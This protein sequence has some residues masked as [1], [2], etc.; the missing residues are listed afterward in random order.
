MY[1]IQN[2]T[3]KE[4][5]LPEGR[6]MKG[7]FLKVKKLHTPSLTA[8]IQ[9]GF[10]KVVHD[11]TSTE[12]ALSLYITVDDALFFEKNTRLLDFDPVDV[13]SMS[14]LDMNKISPSFWGVIE[15]LADCWG[16][17]LMSPDD[18]VNDDGTIRVPNKYEGFLDGYDGF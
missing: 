9:A 1:T 14:S 3:N 16:F 13:V 10:L 2:I 4:L 12:D 7:G 6:I 17:L 15:E 5:M 8:A 18:M 11:D